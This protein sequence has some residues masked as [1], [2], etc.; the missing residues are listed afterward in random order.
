[1]EFNTIIRF[2]WTD[3]KR[4]GIWVLKQGR[5]CLDIIYLQKFSK[6]PSEQDIAKVKQKFPDDL[7]EICPENLVA[8]LK[9][10]K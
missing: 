7:V 1:M 10:E 8:W 4:Y 9:K 5:G 6:Q 3:Y 2:F